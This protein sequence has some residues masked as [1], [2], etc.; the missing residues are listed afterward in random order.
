MAAAAKTL[1]TAQT[2]TLRTRPKHTLTQNGSPR[3]A[4]NPVNPAHVVRK[5]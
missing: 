5:R 3:Y 4:N 1:S 2:A